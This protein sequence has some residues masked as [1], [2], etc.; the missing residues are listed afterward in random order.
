M[1]LVQTLGK[2]SEI[3]S[4]S[5]PFIFLFHF[6]SFFFSFDLTLAPILRRKKLN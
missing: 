3:N 6:F 2:V 4:T 1:Y 5:L